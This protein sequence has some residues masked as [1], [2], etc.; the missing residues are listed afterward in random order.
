MRILVVTSEWPTPEHPEAVPFIVRRVEALRT[1]GVEVDVFSFRGAR[2]PA[3]Y[4]AAYRRIQSVLKCQKYDL[5]HA[6][7]GQSG[8]LVFAPKLHPLVVTFH[9]SDVQGIVNADG[10][11]QRGA[12]ALLRNVSRLVALRADEVIISSRHL[13]KHLP[14]RTF[15]VIPCGVDL[16]V[17]RP[18]DRD[19]AR[20]TLG[21]SKD[22]RF[23][24]FAANPK[25][26]VKRYWLAEQAVGRLK[27]SYD[28]D[29]LV[30]ANIPHHQMP[31]YINA[32]DAVILTSKHE[33]SPT[34][35]K[36]ALACNVPIISVDVGDVR[37]RLAGV[38]GCFVCKTDAPVEIAASL[39]QALRTGQRIDGHAAVRDLDESRL[40]QQVIAVYHRALTKASQEVIT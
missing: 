33:G 21:L 10:D 14:R 29:I 26:S 12:S 31:V 23:V 3:R 4:V 19:A 40:V 34:I 11:Y 15:H 6:E 17:F 27:Q 7:F 8:L 24:L 2:N 32:S 20:V 9:G 13:A 5:I 1:A 38:S 22:R 39:E 16:E 28:V 37:E 30:T 36:E 35:V 18:L 25:R